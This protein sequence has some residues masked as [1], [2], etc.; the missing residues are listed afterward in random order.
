M[1]EQL[2]YYVSEKGPQNA[3]EIAVCTCTSEGMAEPRHQL[4]IVVRKRCTG[5]ASQL[6]RK[7]V[8]RFKLFL[9]QRPQQKAWLSVYHVVL[10]LNPY[11]S[12]FAKEKLGQKS[13]EQGNPK[14]AGEDF[15]KILH[16][17]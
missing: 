14:G 2:T 10:R 6:R 1:N 16:E 11:A 4:V 5:C 13:I 17:N 9:I 7:T 15:T 3:K 12:A 8:S